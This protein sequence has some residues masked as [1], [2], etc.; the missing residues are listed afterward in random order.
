MPSFREKLAL[1]FDPIGVGV[2]GKSK[3]VAALGNKI[4]AHR[5]LLVGRIK[6]Y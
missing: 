1:G 5:D 4:G 6:L 2:A 3:P